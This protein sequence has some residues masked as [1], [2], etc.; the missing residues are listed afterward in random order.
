MVWREIVA[1]F[2]H[3]SGW[4]VALVMSPALLPR[5]VAL[6]GPS[7]LSERAMRILRRPPFPPPPATPGP[8][9]P[10]YET[11]LHSGHTVVWRW[12]DGLLRQLW[13]AWWRVWPGMPRRDRH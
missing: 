9:P 6:F 5:L 12:M 1:L 8:G 3:H 10:S 13:H 4:L 2:T 7:W 11:P